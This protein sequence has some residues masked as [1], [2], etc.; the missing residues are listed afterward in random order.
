[1]ASHP[2]ERYS[3]P[4]G[5]RRVT[6]SSCELS[7][8]VAEL[9]PLQAQALASGADGESTD[10]LADAHALVADVLDVYPCRHRVGVAGSPDLD[11]FDRQ[12]SAGRADGDRGTSTAGALTALPADCSHVR[13]EADHL[14][15]Q[16]GD[17]D[18]LEA[19]P[20][21]RGSRRRR[22]SDALDVRD[23]LEVPCGIRVVRLGR[24]GDDT[25]AERGCR[26]HS[27]CCTA[28]T[29]LRAV[30]KLQF[31]FHGSS[32]LFIISSGDAAGPVLVQTVNI[33]WNTPAHTDR[34]NKQTN[35]W[36]VKAQWERNIAQ[37]SLYY[38]INI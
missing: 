37:P 16:L 25:H 13:L 4:L 32:F 31:V 26:G 12:A 8:Q 7:S 27:E 23:D 35:K 15:L 24:R 9:E 6:T 1:M 3:P 2:G 14:A 34:L 17:L 19:K 33:S 5:G 10:A 38:I 21:A 11:G 36:H 30:Q 18:G 28:H 22:P 20:L 29:P